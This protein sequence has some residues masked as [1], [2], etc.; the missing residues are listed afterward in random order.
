MKMIL[1]G[2]PGAGKGTQASFLS[3]KFD[4]PAIS[5]GAIIR[6]EIA[7]GSQIGKAVKK[8]IDAG[9]LLSDE[10]VIELV[11]VRLS[12]PDCEKGFIL[13]GFPRTLAQARALESMGVEIDTVLSI[14]LSDDEIVR[15]LAGR[16]ECSECRRPYNQDGHAPKVAGVCDECGGKLIRRADDEPETIKNRLSVYHEQTEPL[17]EYYVQKGLLTVAYSQN[18][19]ED[20]KREVLKALSEMLE[21]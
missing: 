17:K 19:L 14:E 8:S 21:A 13:D 6:E 20:T 1:L 10:F 4:I 18:K 11:K 3:A 16:F 15:R 2:P 5:T 9:Q 12:K 7:S